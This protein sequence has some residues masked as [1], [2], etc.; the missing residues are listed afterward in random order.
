MDFVQELRQLEPQVAFQFEHAVHMADLATTA[1]REASRQSK[2]VVRICRTARST[3]T[4][5]TTITTAATT[6]TTTTI[7]IGGLPASHAAD[8]LARRLLAPPGQTSTQRRLTA[9]Q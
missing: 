8:S 1:S 2:A 7:T 3:T 4:I 5:T 6:T 9:V